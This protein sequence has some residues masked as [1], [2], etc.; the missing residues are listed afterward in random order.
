MGFKT[1]LVIAS[2][3]FCSCTNTKSRNLEN[4]R[5]EQLKE[6]S[7]TLVVICNGEEYRLEVDYDQE[8]KFIRVFNE[9][10]IYKRVNLP[11]QLD[12]SGFSLNGFLKTE[13]GF[14]VSVEYGSINYYQK[15]FYFQCKQNGFNLHQIRTSSFNKRD[16]SKESVQDSILSS[17]MS[18]KDFMFIPFL[19]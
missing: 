17:Q 18:L 11:S 1:I 19:E 9:N 12:Y 16:P 7:D 6:L 14:I 8:S 10:K 5:N 2:L 4:L 13:K 15:E 3:I